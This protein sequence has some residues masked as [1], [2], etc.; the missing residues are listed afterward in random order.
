MTYLLVLLAVIGCMALMDAR[1]R[2]LLW[3]RP[4]AG[5]LA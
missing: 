5:G 1:W 3:R 2:L 4:V